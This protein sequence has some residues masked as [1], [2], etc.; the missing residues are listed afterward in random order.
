MCVR[1]DVKE[2]LWDLL[3]KYP[4][5]EVTVTYEPCEEVLRE[6][7]D[8]KK[9][10]KIMGSFHVTKPDDI[11]VVC[12][13]IDKLNISG[14]QHRISVYNDIKGNSSIGKTNIS[15]TEVRYFFEK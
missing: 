13:L 5:E 6:E 11:D 10:L 3:K 7:A 15:S 12:E 14:Y 1:E 4:L 8:L 2:Q 9:H